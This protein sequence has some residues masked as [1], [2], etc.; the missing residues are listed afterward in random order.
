MIEFGGIWYEP[1]EEPR[2]GMLSIEITKSGGFIADVKTHSSYPNITKVDILNCAVLVNRYLHTLKEKFTNNSSGENPFVNASSG[3]CLYS[4]KFVEDPPY[5]KQAGG[6]NYG[7][8]YAEIIG[9]LETIKSHY[10]I[11]Q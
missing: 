8:T 10:K 5:V 1:Y 11:Q 4:V 3:S 6:T 9:V 2:S 7:L